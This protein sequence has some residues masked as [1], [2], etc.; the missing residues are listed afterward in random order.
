MVHGSQQ[1][2]AVSF[3]MLALM[4]MLEGTR[5]ANAHSK[6]PDPINAGVAAR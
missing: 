6:L 4:L 1:Y 5:D 2:V 3:V